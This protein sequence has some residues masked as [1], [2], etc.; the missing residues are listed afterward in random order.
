MCVGGDER[1]STL[2]INGGEKITNPYEVLR[3]REKQ[4]ALFM[5]KERKCLAKG[6]GTRKEGDI[7]TQEAD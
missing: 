6:I 3:R 7:Y 2:V 1:K 5:G 4:M